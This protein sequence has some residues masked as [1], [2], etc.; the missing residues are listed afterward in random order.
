MENLPNT[1]ASARRHARASR[2][3]GLALTA[4]DAASW[5][6]VAA[7]LRATLSPGERGALA[8]AALASCT[9]ED[10]DHILDRLPAEAG[11]PLTPF[12]AVKAE[13]LSWAAVASTPEKRA[14]AAAAYL[15]LGA[16]DRRAFLDAFA[17][18]VAA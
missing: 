11:P 7:I 17:P 6:N 12:T 14:Y 13:A 4:A 2:A 16:P 5:W 10:L 3:L 9:E 8:V 15:A 18:G 1:D